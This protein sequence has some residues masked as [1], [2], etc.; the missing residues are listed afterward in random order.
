MKNK[1]DQLD[2]NTILKVLPH[3]QPFLLIDRVLEY[4]ANESGPRTGQKVKVIKNVT[5]NEP[6][7][8]GHFPHHP[9]MPGVLILE[10]MAQAAAFSVWREGDPEM[11]VAIA[12]LSE[13]RFH[14][15]VIPGDTLLIEAE[16]IKDKGTMLLFK[17]KCSVEGEHVTEVEILAHVAP[18][19][20]MI[21]A[22]S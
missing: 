2:I 16:V 22:R 5:Y 9:I 11:N 14:R 19:A 21:N 7:F 20:E 6:F 18:K 4:Y 17:A 8:N 10:A 1:S 13:A 15:P 3:R 12:R